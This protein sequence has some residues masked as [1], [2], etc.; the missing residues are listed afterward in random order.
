VLRSLACVDAVEVF[1]EDTPAAALRRL[2][3][4]LFVKGAD[5]AGRQ[6]D[7]AAVLGEWGGET[8]LLPV[9]D[10]RSTTTLIRR[11]LADAG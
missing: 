6:L 8:V 1:D 5:Y 2:R 9:L 7:E 10:G 3:P 4:D 11:A